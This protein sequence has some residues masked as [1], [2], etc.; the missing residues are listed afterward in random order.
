MGSLLKVVA[1]GVLVCIFYQDLKE[2]EVFWFLFPLLAFSL[3]IVHYLNVDESLI[4]GYFVLLNTLLVTGIVLLLFLIH[5][6]WI[7]KPFLNHSFGLGDLLFFYAFAMGFPT[8]TFVVLFANS[9]LFSLVVYLFM[10]KYR[11]VN[12][13]P[14]AGLMGLFVLTVLGLS[15]F[16]KTPSLYTF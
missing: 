4:F 6:L 1:C 11:Q 13:V 7:Q 12:T 5:K 2:R 3:A 9:L 10:K 16:I 15:I 14:L 8:M